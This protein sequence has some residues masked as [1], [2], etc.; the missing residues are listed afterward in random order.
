MKEGNSKGACTTADWFRRKASARILA[1]GATLSAHQP[2]S[3]VAD[4]SDPAFL[5]IVPNQ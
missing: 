2:V 4:E 1:C 3:D 5:A